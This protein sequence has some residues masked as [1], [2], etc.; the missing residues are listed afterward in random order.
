MKRL[1]SI[2]LTITFLLSSAFTVF[3]EDSTNT[4]YPQKF[5]DVPKSH[6]AFNEIAELVNKG[7][8]AGYND[9]SFKP[10]NTV[11]RAEWAKIMVLAA[12]LNP[13]DNTVYFNDM[14]GHWANT[15]VNSAKEYLTTYSDG[16]FKPDQAAAR[17]DVTVSMVKLKGYD[18]SNVDYSYLSQFTDTD[19]ISNDLK[20]YVA[21]AVEKEL[22]DGFEDNTFRGQATLTRAQAATLL[23]R[24]FRYG[25]DNKVADSETV[26]DPSVSNAQSTSTLVSFTQEPTAKPTVEPTKEPIAE[27]EETPEPTPTPKPYYIDSIKIVDMMGNNNREHYLYERPYYSIGDRDIYYADRDSVI[28]KVNIDTG[29]ETVLLDLNEEIQ[30]LSDEDDPS[31]D[32]DNIY[33]EGGTLKQVFYDKYQHGLILT[34]YLEQPQRYYYFTVNNGCLE[35]IL[36]ENEREDRFVAS[37]PN[38]RLIADKYIYDAT[39]GIQISRSNIP[40]CCGTVLYRDNKLYCDSQGQVF[41]TDFINCDNIDNISGHSSAFNG[42]YIYT[43]DGLENIKKYTLSGAEKAGIKSTDIAVRDGISDLKGQLMF[44]DQGEMIIFNGTT[45]RILKETS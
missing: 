34:V 7:V 45:F 16:S 35:K 20:K 6:W 33:M 3:A 4:D 23:W 8:I 19:S 10:D 9:G 29:N 26:E 39:N 21:I 17:E 30:R 38:N 32:E 2:I 28:R 13:S 41:V 36:K 27:P 25:N 44:T 1:T 5:W 37:L 24:A 11:T 42:D 14:S 43:S 40:V 18:T 12:G 22:I 15:Y 31:S